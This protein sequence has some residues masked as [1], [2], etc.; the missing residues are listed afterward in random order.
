MSVES[1]PSAVVSV[2][3]QESQSA[4]VSV[5]SQPSAVVSVDGASTRLQYDLRAARPSFDGCWDAPMSATLSNKFFLSRIAATLN[6]LRKGKRDCCQHHCLKKFQP[7]YARSRVLQWRKQWHLLSQHQQNQL[8]LDQVHSQLREVQGYAPGI[9]GDGQQVATRILPRS[10][11]STCKFLG[12][13]VCTRA[14]VVLVGCSPKRIVAARRACA[15]GHIVAKK[16]EVSKRKRHLL[17]AMHGAVMVLCKHLHERMPFKNHNPKNIDLPL[18]RKRQ[19]FMMLKSWYSKSVESLG[20]DKSI[21][22]G[23]QPLLPKKPKYR[24][25]LDVLR[26]PEF[27]NVRFHRVV[28]IGRCAKCAFYNWKLLVVGAENREIWER[29]AA[30]HQWLQLAQKKAYAVDRAQAANT[31]P[32]RDGELYIGIDGGSGFEVHLPHL[33]PFAV[34]GPNKAVEKHHTLPFKVMNGLVHGDTRSHVLLSPGSIVAAFRG[35]VRL[36]HASPSPEAC[37][38]EWH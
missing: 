12:H 4:M 13:S 9:Q 11:K 33:S 34:E 24:T 31:F 29:L 36:P 16:R 8:I 28:N 3:S 17:D 1:Q 21:S 15:A 14:W 27:E 38:R 10:R 18:A 19:L 35:C 6:T 7:V 37:I 32:S 30:K 2:E 26:Q 22:S 25:F 5:E 20:P 23:R